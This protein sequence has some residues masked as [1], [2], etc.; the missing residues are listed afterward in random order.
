MI[1]VFLTAM[2]FLSL[3]GSASG[4]AKLLVYIP[5]VSNVQRLQTY[6][7]GV[8]GAGQ[9]SVFGRLIDLQTMIETKPD[10][11]LIVPP[12]FFHYVT[13]YK[14]YL[15]GKFQ[16][17]TGQKY[18]LVTANS[19]VTMDNISQKKTGV[20]NFIGRENLPDFINRQFGFTTKLIKSV[21]KKEDLL[22]MLGLSAADA[23]IISKAEYT[24]MLSN[25]KIPLTILK[26]SAQPVGHVVCAAKPGQ[27]D[28]TLKRIL[29]NSLPEDLIKS[30]GL[31]KWEAE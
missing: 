11:S 3:M 26:E 20:V 10:V 28:A 23:I 29:S 9:A 14:P 5:G 19:E 4:Q 31:E 16:K 21:N 8:L 13:D 1:K 12:D 22:T 6:F 24:E 2:L 7:D 15:I 27:E 18:L 17:Q 30:L 25:T